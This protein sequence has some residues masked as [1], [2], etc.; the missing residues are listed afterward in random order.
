MNLNGG[1]DANL[2]WT[3]RRAIW[4][5]EVYATATTPPT[6]ISGFDLGL[7]FQAGL[8]LIMFFIYFRNR[9]AS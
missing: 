3:E 5:G 8:T 1:Y 2:K 9:E 7:P 4:K 6:F